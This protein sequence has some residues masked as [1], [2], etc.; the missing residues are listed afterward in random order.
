M[1]CEGDNDFKVVGDEEFN[2]IKIGKC[3]TAHNISQVLKITEQSK[4]AIP[5]VER[6]KPAA[7]SPQLLQGTDASENE[8][9]RLQYG[10]ALLLQWTHT[11]HLKKDNENILGKKLHF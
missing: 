6:N 8:D 9:R 10:I 2:P 3:K 4:N 7:V 1:V 11:R 5:R